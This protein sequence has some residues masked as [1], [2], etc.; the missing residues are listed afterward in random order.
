MLG[1]GFTIILDY[2]DVLSQAKYST[3]LMSNWIKKDKGN[4]FSHLISPTCVDW[5]SSP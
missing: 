1:L 2:C 4:L 3:T 5:H